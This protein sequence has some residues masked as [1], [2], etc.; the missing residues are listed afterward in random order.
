MGKGI[1]DLA[2]CIAALL[3]IALNYTKEE[4]VVEHLSTAIILVSLIQSKKF[5][6]FL[7][8]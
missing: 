4:V 3:Q 2:H 7:K 6:D 5:Y 8:A 1:S